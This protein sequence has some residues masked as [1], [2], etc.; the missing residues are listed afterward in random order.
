MNKFWVAVPN[1]DTVNFICSETTNGNFEYEGSTEFHT[2]YVFESE[3]SADFTVDVNGAPV[4]AE[5]IGGAH[6]PQRPK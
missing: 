4:T 6:S 2:N 1:D 3:E 5:L